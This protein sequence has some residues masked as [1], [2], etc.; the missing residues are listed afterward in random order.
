MA[1]I[2]YPLSQ[3]EHR[4]ISSTQRNFPFY[5]HNLSLA[6]GN[7][8]SFLITKISFQE[9][10]IKEIFEISFKKNILLEYN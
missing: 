6:C 5:S 3:S 4:M 8:K 7:H 10:Y 1:Q 2:V 9:Y